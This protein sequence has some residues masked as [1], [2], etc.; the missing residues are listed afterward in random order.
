MEPSESADATTEYQSIGQPDQSIQSA[1]P[2]LG[3]RKRPKIRPSIHKAVARLAA[4]LGAEG[5]FLGDDQAYTTKLL[6]LAAAS[7]EPDT[8][9]ASGLSI[10]AS[11]AD[12]LQVCCPFSKPP[13]R[14]LIRA[15]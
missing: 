12:K 1:P 3:S 4:T 9:D 6:E 7:Y 14:E 10:N 5:P 8:V 11:E 15:G 2:A 13:C